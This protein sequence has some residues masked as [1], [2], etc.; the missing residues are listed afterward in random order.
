MSWQP[1]GST[2]ERRPRTQEARRAGLTFVALETQTIIYEQI[3]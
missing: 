3:K 2:R 1:G